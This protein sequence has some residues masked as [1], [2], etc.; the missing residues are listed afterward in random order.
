MVLSKNIHIVFVGFGA[1]WA[2]LAASILVGEWDELPAGLFLLA[3]GVLSA[4][5]GFLGSARLREFVGGIGSGSISIAW[6]HRDRHRPQVPCSRSHQG[7]C[8]AG[9]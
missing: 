1:F 8:R 2:A 3:V 4:L 7:G 6:V 5:W 9:P